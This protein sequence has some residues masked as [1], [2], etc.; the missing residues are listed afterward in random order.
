MLFRSDSAGEFRLTNVPVG[1]VKVTAFRTGVPPQAQT[2]NVAAGQITRQNFELAYL[3]PAS[4]KGDR[5]VQLDRFT[6][7]T[8]KEMDGAA[9]AI[10]TQRFAAN[11]MNVVAAN[12]FGPVA[13]GGVGEVLKSVSG[14]SIA[15]GGFGDAYQVSLHGAPPRNVPITVGGISLANSAAL[16]SE[17]FLW[18]TTRPSRITDTSSDMAITSSSLWVITTMVF[19]CCRICRR[20][21]KNSR[22]S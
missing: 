2:V 12:E 5:V 18:P 14:I 19:P 13:D 16:V 15:R 9:I 22:T 4:A 21:L 7:S 10:N 3:Q 6:V 11:T 1:T 20:I 17:V 8:P